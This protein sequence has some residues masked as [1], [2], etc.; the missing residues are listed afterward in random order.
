MLRRINDRFLD[1]NTALAFVVLL[2]LIDAKFPLPHSVS[3]ALLCS[4]F[5]VGIPTMSIH[6]TCSSARLCA[7]IN[8]RSNPALPQGKL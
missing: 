4:G 2:K 6:K 3:I 1:Y 8:N 5:V 7:T